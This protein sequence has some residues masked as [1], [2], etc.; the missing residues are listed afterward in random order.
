MMLGCV[1][2]HHD[3]APGPGWLGHG[4]EKLDVAVA[5]SGT[6]L[7]ISTLARLEAQAH[8]GH[9]LHVIITISGQRQE[10]LKILR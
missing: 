5:G 2:G 7:L 3:A 9:R 10:A 6:G 8:S 4:V 1:L